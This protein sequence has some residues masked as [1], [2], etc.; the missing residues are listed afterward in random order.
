[1]KKLFTILFSFMFVLVCLTGCTPKSNDLKSID[2]VQNVILLI[3]DGMGDSHI[4]NAKQYFDI[5]KFDFE[6]DFK[7][8]VKTE[9]LDGITDSAAAATALATGNKAHKKEVGMSDGTKFENIMEMAAKSGKKTGVITTDKLYGATPACFSSHSSDRNNKEEIID[10]QLED[11]LDL[12]I[13]LSSST[14]KARKDEFIEKGYVYSTDYKDIENLTE[15]QKYLGLFSNMRSKYNED[16]K[17]SHLEEI[18]SSSLEFLDNEN[19]FFLMIENAYID[20]CSHD[21]DYYGM[22]CEV[23]EFADMINE[24]Y[25]FASGRKDTLVM[26]TADHETGGLQTA[27]FKEELTDQLFSKTSHTGVN[28]NFYANLK[29]NDTNIID[30]TDIFKYFKLVLENKKNALQM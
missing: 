28:V 13:G 18:I 15:E 11:G 16:E 26:I 24:V 21:N 3:G 7:G 14:Y 12:M 10:G 20:K 25:K 2:T 23:R 6:D 19:G 5:D 27:K 8:R 17:Q 30:N 29:L 4:E 9:C 1:M 22:V